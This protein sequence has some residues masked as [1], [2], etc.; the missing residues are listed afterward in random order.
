[1]WFVKC[2]KKEHA[3]TTKKV[4]VGELEGPL[5][6]TG[7][8]TYV[9]VYMYVGPETRIELMAV[10]GSNLKILQIS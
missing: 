3:I 6:A 1:M 10:K 9:H 7:N 4:R 8:T 5:K 2:K